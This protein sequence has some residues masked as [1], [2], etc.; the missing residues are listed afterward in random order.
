M[1]LVLAISLVFIGLQSQIFITFGG[2]VEVKK[3]LLDT[4]DISHVKSIPHEDFKAGNY[5]NPV[6][7]V[8]GDGGSRLQAKLDR[9]DVA[10]HYCERKSNDWFDL[11]LNLSLLVPFAIDC[12]VEK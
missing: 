7:L 1:K 2:S 4:N 5:L 3:N 9:R 10:H 8:P 12:W 6:I 11:W